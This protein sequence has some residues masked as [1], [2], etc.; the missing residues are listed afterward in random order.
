MAAGRQTQ[1][2]PSRFRAG[3]Q[4]Q[5]QARQVY[6]GAAD[7]SR[8]P[9]SAAERSRQSG[10]THQA[11]RNLQAGNPAGRRRANGRHKVIIQASRQ[12]GSR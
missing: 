1:A 12:A 2:E 10:E 9:G 11:G 7:P 3:R 6:P 4:T 5:V 8:K